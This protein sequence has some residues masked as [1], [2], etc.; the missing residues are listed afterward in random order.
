MSFASKFNKEAKKFN[1]NTEGFEYY[2]LDD[3]FENNGADEIYPLRGIYINKK[4]KYGDS[5]VAITDEFCAYLPQHM[6]NTVNK[7]LE[8]DEAVA[9]INAGKVGFSIYQYTDEKHNKICYSIR[10]EDIEPKGTKKK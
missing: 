4:G 8:D 5:P 2:K 6:M 1:I 7:I 10:F 9:E 3:L